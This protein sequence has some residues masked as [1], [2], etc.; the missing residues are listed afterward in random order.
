[1]R[2]LARNFATLLTS[3]CVV[4]CGATR[5]C[6]IDLVSRSMALWYAFCNVQ[7]AK[8]GGGRSPSRRTFSGAGVIS[9][10]NARPA[11]QT[12]GK[13]SLAAVVLA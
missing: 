13:L 5:A 12:V 2:A 3:Y 4:F 11:R 7:I 8:D 1:M 10:A 6:G 9:P